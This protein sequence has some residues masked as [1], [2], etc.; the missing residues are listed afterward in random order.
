[1][2]ADI[3]SNFIS[4]ISTVDGKMLILLAMDRLISDALVEQSSPDKVA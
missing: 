1:M 2:S 4:G 3:D